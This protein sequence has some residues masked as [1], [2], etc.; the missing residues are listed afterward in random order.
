MAHLYIVIKTIV[1]SDPNGN[2]TGEIVILL[3]KI[4]EIWK[5]KIILRL[6]PK[7]TYQNHC[8]LI[9]GWVV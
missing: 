1:Y 6:T 2:I 3:G 5:R 9:E 4:E 7:K 8:L